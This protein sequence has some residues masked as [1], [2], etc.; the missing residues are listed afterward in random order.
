MILVAFS[1]MKQFSVAISIDLYR[2]KL[3]L[4]GQV[5][6]PLYQMTDDSR[7]TSYARFFL[8]HTENYVGVICNGTS[9]F[10]VFLNLKH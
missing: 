1:F 9:N 3:E 2:Q 6:E 10:N 8:F 5:I 7:D 4:Q